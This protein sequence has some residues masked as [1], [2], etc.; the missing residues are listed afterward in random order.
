MRRRLLVAR[1]ALCACGLAMFAGCTFLIDFQEVTK[2]G[3]GGADSSSIGIGPPDVTVDGNPGPGLDGALADAG[4]DV[5]DAIAN[6][7]ACKGHQD[8]KYCGGDQ[9]TWPGSRDDLV[10]CKNGQV[11]LVKLCATGQGC[12]GMLNGFPDECDEC[13][14]KADGTYCGRDLPGWD[15]SNA[16]QRV[17]CQTSR[18]VGL[19]LCAV[20]KSAGINSSCQ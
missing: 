6:A 8:G 4:S 9:I 13:A 19:L 7:D 3:D 10:T 18:E 14:K 20:C 5:R 12:I 16:Q 17:R 2:T 15:V 11:S 1:V